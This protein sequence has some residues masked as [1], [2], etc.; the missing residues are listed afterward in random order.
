M[1]PK[2]LPALGRQLVQVLALDEQVAQGEAQIRQAVLVGLATVPK[3]QLETQP[4]LISSQGGM[5]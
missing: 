4:P 2:R 5:H 3:G 1:F